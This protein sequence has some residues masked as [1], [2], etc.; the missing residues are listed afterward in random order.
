M[1]LVKEKELGGGGGKRE[2]E[3]STEWR[4]EVRREGRGWAGEGEGGRDG[5]GRGEEM[6]GEG[7]EQTPCVSASA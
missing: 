5:K 6:V 2:G 4:G 1:N 3:V 7:K